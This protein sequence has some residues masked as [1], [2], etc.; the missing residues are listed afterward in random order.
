M[1]Q[2]VELGL[3]IFVGLLLVN[4]G[5]NKFIGYMPMPEMAEPAGAL[6]M[7]LVGSGYIMATVAVVEIIGGVLLIWGKMIPFALIILAPIIYNIFMVHAILD[8]NGVAIG[9]ILIAALGWFAWN[10]KG[11]FKAL[12]G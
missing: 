5:I 8:P 6:M 3:R 12:F 10:R 4:S 11:S 9:V 1:I 2:K 7:A